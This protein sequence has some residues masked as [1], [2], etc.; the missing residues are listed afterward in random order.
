MVGSYSP[1]NRWHRNLTNSAA[2]LGNMGQFKLDSLEYNFFNNINALLSDK[3]GR[4][5]KIKEIIHKKKI[6]LAHSEKSKVN[7]FQKM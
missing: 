4:E 7:F 6:T 5:E 3:E 1:M 2:K